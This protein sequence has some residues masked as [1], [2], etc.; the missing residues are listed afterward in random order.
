MSEGVPTR[1]P[2]LSQFSEIDAA[3]DRFEDDWRAGRRPRIEDYLDAVPEPARPALLRELLMLELAYRRLHGEEATPDEYRRRLPAHDELILAA[4]E[5]RSGTYTEVVRPLGCTPGETGRNLLLGLLGA[6]MGLLDGEALI[7]ALETWARDRSRPLGMVL[8]ER[9]A[10]DDDKLTLL[11]K[12]VAEHLRR[13]GDDPDRSLS[14]I[15]LDA[16]LHAGLKRVA[17]PE[18]QSYLL[19]AAAGPATQDPEATRAGVEVGTGVT[20]ASVGGAPTPRGLRYRI[21]RWHAQGGL[22]IVY[23]ASDE[24]LHRQVAL[25]EM[26]DR[27]ADSPTARVRFLLEAQITGGLEHPGIV[28]VYGLGH[29]PDGRPFYAMRFIKGDSLREAIEHF[30]RDEERD[31]DPGRRRL[32][33]RELLRRFLDVC[34][35]MAYAHSRGVIHRDLKPANI[36]LGQYG[37]TLVVDW[38][39]AKP[40]NRPE[41]AP[42]G[43][44]L[45]LAP[46]GSGSAETLPGSAVGTPQYMSPE[47]AAGRLDRL[48]PA[49]DVYS[50]GATLYSLLTG[51]APVESR[52]IVEILDQ[53]Q[54]GE[55]PPPR[56]VNPW[57]PRALEA[58]CLR[59]M[60]LRPED[61]YGSPAALAGDIE[62]WL[63]DEPVSAYAE[64]W[65]ARLGRWARRHRSA[66][67]AAGLLL[68]AV[69]VIATVAA[70]LVDGS[71]RTAERARF[72]EADARRQAETQQYLSDVALAGREWMAG[73]M[74]RV[75]DLLNGCPADPRHWEWHFLKR[76]GGAGLRTLVGPHVGWVTGLAFSPDGKRL[77]SA[78]WH[79]TAKVWDVTAGDVALD[80]DGAAGH[81]GHVLAVAYSSDGKRLATAGKD[82]TVRLWDAADGRPGPVLK[83]HQ[84]PV[85]GVAFS[86]DGKL[87]ATAGHDRLVKLW[88]AANG[89]AWLTLPGHEAPVAAVTFRPDGRLLATAGESPD[90]AIRLWDVATGKEVRRLTGHTLNINAL[91]FRPDGRILASAGND[92]LVP[93]WDVET[94]R[95]AGVVTTGESKMVK[96]VAFR[97]DGKVLVTGGL[98]QTIRVWDP[99]TAR[100]LYALRG[101]DAGVLCLAFRP[102]GRVLAS[103]SEDGII[104]LWDAA[105]GPEFVRLAVPEQ[106][107]AA[108]AFSPDG[109]WIA[110]AAL[111]REANPRGG[112]VRLWE[113]VG[114]RPGPVLEGH[115]DDVSDLAFDPDGRRLAA[116]GSRGLVSVWEL[117]SGRKL[118]RLQGP[119][120]KVA[121][122]HRPHVAFGPDGRELACVGVTGSVVVWEATGGRVARS[123]SAAHPN[124]FGFGP[125]VL[126]FSP[127][128]RHL[129][130]GEIDGAVHL[131]DVA[132]GREVAALRGGQASFLA[133]ALSPDGRLLAI[134]AARQ[135]SATASAEIK[136]W[137]LAS[138][139]ELA[140]FAGPGGIAELAISPDGRR[141]AS[142]GPHL[143]ATLWDLRSGRELLNLPIDGRT[144]LNE[145]ASGPDSRIAFSPD[146]ARLALV[147][148]GGL[149]IWDAAAGPEVLTLHT[150][151]EVMGLDYS[152]DG[153]RLA[154]ADSEDAVRVRDAATGR[155][156]LTLAV[157]DWSMGLALSAVK[158][159]PDG[160]RLAA[161]CGT[162]TSGRV[163]IWDTTTGRLV[164]RLDGHTSFV[165]NLAFSPDGRRIATASHDK[166]AKV[167]DAVNGRLLRTILAHADLVNAVAFSPDGTRLVTGG[168]DR[169]L[170]L[171]DT[172]SGRELMTLR[173][174]KGNV[175]G[176]AFRPDGTRLVSVGGRGTGSPLGPPRGE[177]KVWDPATG[178]EVLRLPDYPRQFLSVAFSPDGRS[179]AA[180]GEDRVVRV[181]DASTGREQF[182]LRGHENTIMRVAFRPSGASS[183]RAALIRRYVSGTS[184]RQRPRSVPPRRPR[185]EA[186]PDRGGMGRGDTRIGR[187]ATRRTGCSRRPW[188]RCANP[189]N[190]LRLVGLFLGQEEVNRGRQAQLPQASRVGIQEQIGGA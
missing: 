49:S 157:P 45:P 92:G 178:R 100:P 103:G 142:T 128:G 168:R 91:A 180:A 115:D 166:T 149:M 186:L 148:F 160:T 35:A 169:T 80:L 161:A 121:G 5:A 131:W 58:I 55:F 47:Q 99:E 25:K 132:G 10:L 176:V 181:W 71:R 68:A 177:V 150:G 155:V 117:P 129:A 54:R 14:T 123:F 97:P 20:L 85:A 61:R 16:A 1:R 36:L 11:D 110:S 82:G 77:G 22:G 165:F 89:E 15:G 134:A 139:R 24:E 189:L 75:E 163:A 27:H 106:R 66:V 175:V 188:T 76:Q 4:F 152:P 57:I 59:A 19:L 98:D 136:V 140:T 78:G 102:D 7:A 17:D 101:H 67:V 135:S 88:N 94:G 164:A 130:A 52:S 13:H 127:D 93:F 69:A 105:S 154:V 70:I 179:V 173:G 23:L 64:P 126:G 118:R 159:S 44:E 18:I 21:V 145:R 143:P 153:R 43:E 30:H 90:T 182:A 151:R 170:R 187:R 8:R 141:I 144:G 185:T 95:L 29:Y 171:W 190:P 162:S 120:G 133:I 2:G 146:G 63:A 114:G 113:A 81:T 26:Q 51:R 42:D 107:H 9:G 83:G 96:A 72:A 6:Q 174:H 138:R 84:G 65:P 53:V 48:G 60:A 112:T 39:L 137:D 28:P 46:S 119:S 34:N 116:V 111:P 62:R 56:Q 125:S 184:R 37:E 86:P 79:G 73:N 158:F 33:L 156:L 12:A 3:C 124:R 40:L 41:P 108:L 32:E 38:G 147:G 167:W 31:R 109:R 122:G 87:L 172:A 104:K 183:P 74:T 50:L